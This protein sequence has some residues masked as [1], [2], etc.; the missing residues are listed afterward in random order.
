MIN[1]YFFSI[2]L[3]IVFIINVKANNLILEIGQH[4]ISQEDIKLKKTTIKNIFKAK[5][6][7]ENT[8]NIDDSNAIKKITFAYTKIKLKEKV[9]R[10]VLTSIKKEYYSKVITPKAIQEYISKTR[11]LVS[12]DIKCDQMFLEACEYIKK[13][14]EPKKY[15]I[16]YKKYKKKGYIGSFK[17]FKSAVKSE[18]F[19]KMTRKDLKNLIDKTVSESEKNSLFTQQLPSYVI[20][21]L[22]KESKEVSEHVKL[23]KK[24]H[25][26]Y[27][28]ILYM[29]WFLSQGKKMGFKIFNKQYGSSLKE[30]LYFSQNPFSLGLD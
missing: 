6:G 10:L 11:K 15:E 19:V 30:I 13:S 21:M 18:A 25:C 27:T 26:N 2:F 9:Y 28:S 7:R 1:K 17:F 3:L 16:A 22:S 20:G 14:K 12:E 29:N 24:H 23:S 8:Q 4:K 5:Y